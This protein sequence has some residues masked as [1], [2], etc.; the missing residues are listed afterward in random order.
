MMGKGGLRGVLGEEREKKTGKAGVCPQTGEKAGNMAPGTAL[1][2]PQG[3]FPD[4]P[5]LKRDVWHPL[6]GSP[7]TGSDLSQNKA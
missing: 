5:E 6:L 2:S 4:A 7:G 1:C 3:T